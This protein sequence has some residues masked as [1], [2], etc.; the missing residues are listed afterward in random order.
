MKGLMNGAVRLVM[1][2]FSF[3]NLKL[4]PACLK[5]KGEESPSEFVVRKSEIRGEQFLEPVESV[6]CLSF[7]SDL[8]LADY[9]LVDAFAKIRKRG[10]RPYAMSLAQFIFSDTEHANSS[11]EF[12][13]VRPSA[14][15][16]LRQ[17]LEQGMWRVL[18]F[19]NHFFKDGEMVEDQ[20]AISVNLVARVP[21][22]DGNG[23]PLVQ[24]QK[25]ESGDRIGDTPIPVEPKLFLRI[26]NGNICVT[27]A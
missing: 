26:E 19:L 7:L 8:A 3:S 1:L 22:V 13:R 25:D 9:V 27:N 11:E 15:L 23:K 18:A 4:V 10:G 5:Q 16:A 21:L 14:E 20:Y 24:W 17:L 2:Q 12:L 6:G